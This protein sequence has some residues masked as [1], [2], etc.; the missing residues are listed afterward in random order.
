MVKKKLIFLLVVFFVGIVSGL[1]LDVVSPIG[2]YTNDTDIDVEYVVD[3]NVSSCW[4]SNDSMSVNWTLDGC[5][6]I[7]DVVWEDGWH[8]VTIWVNDTF[9]NESSDSV[10]FG[11]DTA[12]PYFVNFENQ[13]VCDNGSFGYDISAEDIGVGVD[14]FFVNDTNFSVTCDGVLTNATELLVG[15]YYVNVSVNDS[16]GNFGGLVLSVSVSSCVVEKYCGDGSCDG[17]E[18]CAGCSEDCGECPDDGE[19]DENEGDGGGSG[20]SWNVPMYVREN[21]SDDG[22]YSEENVSVDVISDSEI[23]VE[24]EAGG[25]RSFVTGLGILDFGGAGGMFSPAIVVIT[26]V[27]VL[28]LLMMRFGGGGNVPGKRF[29]Y[30]RYVKMIVGEEPEIAKDYIKGGV[31][32]EDKGMRKVRFRYL[33]RSLFR[34]RSL[35]LF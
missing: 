3:V 5:V 17:D 20:G 18:D 15:E 34:K 9:G 16:L 8:N 31:S 29:N 11:V 13:S 19:D 14:C 25:F 10:G 24:E 30:D 6:N 4:Y 32:R 28:V 22:N 12:S 1:S 21:D 26:F 33:R 7:T 35:S 2:D 27:M 23:F